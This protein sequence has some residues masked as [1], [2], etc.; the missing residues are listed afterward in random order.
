[1]IFVLSYV[2]QLVF[3][4]IFGIIMFFIAGKQTDANIIVSQVLVFLGLF[5]LPLAFIVASF[6]ARAGGKGGALTAV[7]A[8]GVIL[9]TP[10]WYGLFAWL[11]GSNTFYLFVL[12]MMVMLYYA[13]GFVMSGNYV[14]MAMT[15]KDTENVKPED[16]N[17]EQLEA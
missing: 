15:P 12:M 11:I 2:G 3:A 8:L 14:K 1:M 7:I 16:I 9:S 13:L 6:S 10:A 4:L 17:T 5:Q